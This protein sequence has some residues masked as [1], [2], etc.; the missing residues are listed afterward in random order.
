MDAVIKS[1]PLDE[2]ALSGVWTSSFVTTARCIDAAPGTCH[3]GLRRQYG[4][5]LLK[6]LR[7]SASATQ[8]DT[9]A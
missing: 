9:L 7:V 3:A 4:S 1:K 8:N 5:Y 2:K 6:R